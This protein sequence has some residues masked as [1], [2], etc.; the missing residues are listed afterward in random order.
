MGGWPDNRCRRTGTDRATGHRFRTLPLL[1]ING[2]STPGFF[3]PFY[4]LRIRPAIPKCATAASCD[5]LYRVQELEHRFRL[6]AEIAMVRTALGIYVP[7]Q[8]FRREDVRIP[9]GHAFGVDHIKTS[10]RILWVRFIGTWIK[11][12]QIAESGS[13]AYLPTRAHARQTAFATISVC[14]MATSSSSPVSVISTVKMSFASCW[15]ANR[16]LR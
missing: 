16:I 7:S 13:P 12:R 10:W 14:A 15:P 1:T 6:L 11:W 5:C 3:E 2:I 9:A 8:E 4:D